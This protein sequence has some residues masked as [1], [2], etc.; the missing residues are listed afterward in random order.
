MVE[1]HVETRKIQC[2]RGFRTFRFWTRACCVTAMAQ[3]GEKS[4]F[5]LFKLEL[6]KE[7][8]VS[9][10]NGR[11]GTVSATPFWTGFDRWVR[12]PVLTPYFEGPLTTLSI[13]KL[14]APPINVSD[15]HGGR[16]KVRVTW[17]KTISRSYVC[18]YITKIDSIC[19]TF[20]IFRAEDLVQWYFFS[21]IQRVIAHLVPLITGILPW[22]L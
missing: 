18:I 7:S 17:L 10:S 8:G 11:F 13:P 16:F 14:W 2:L 20:R 19:A 21:L 3:T 5:S 9:V 1:I 22:R 4:P 6:G 12:F 15:L